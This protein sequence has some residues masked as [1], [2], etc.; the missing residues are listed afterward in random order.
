MNSTEPALPKSVKETVYRL[1]QAEPRGR[2]V[3]RLS[4]AVKI[5][6]VKLGND[7]RGVGIWQEFSDH[8]ALCGVYAPDPCDDQ[9]P[10]PENAGCRLCRRKYLQI[11]S[12]QNSGGRRS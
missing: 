7:S 4:H 9:A 3:A 12:R 11:F 8:K 10:G 6:R 1:G 5:D 2:I